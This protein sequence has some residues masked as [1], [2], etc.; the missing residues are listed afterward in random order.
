MNFI[1]DINVPDVLG[2][3]TSTIVVSNVAEGSSIDFLSS[4]ES[5]IDLLSE[6]VAA[7]GELIF[8]LGIGVDPIFG[9][10]IGLRS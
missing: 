6:L 10:V 4:V 8:G 3:S 2:F 7:G 5:V 9:L 1:L